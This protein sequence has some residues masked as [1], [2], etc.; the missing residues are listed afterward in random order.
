MNKWEWELR[1]DLMKVLEPFKG[2]GNDVYFPETVHALVGV[3][4]KYA[5]RLNEPLEVE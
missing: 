5:A 4:R 1:A 2:Y 3:F